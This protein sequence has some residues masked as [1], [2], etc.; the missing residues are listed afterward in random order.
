M[1]LGNWKVWR[2]PPALTVPP[3][4]VDTKKDG[5]DGPVPDPIFATHCFKCRI[6][7]AFDTCGAPAPVCAAFLAIKS[8]AF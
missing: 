5:A 4:F 1:D 2:D 7:V 8:L 3:F 6:R